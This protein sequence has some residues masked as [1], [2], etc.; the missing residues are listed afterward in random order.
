MAGDK[1]GRGLGRRGLGEV[2]MVVGWVGFCNVRSSRCMS[3][4]GLL[5]GLL[6]V[7]FVV[8]N[9]YCVIRVN[10]EARRALSRY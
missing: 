4:H 8:G 2:G 1:L 6:G 10:I 5:F 3:A 7:L 9:F